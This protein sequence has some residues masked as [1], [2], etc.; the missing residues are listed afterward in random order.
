MIPSNRLC[1]EPRCYFLT[2]IGLETSA[3][4]GIFGAD[5][6]IRTRSISESLRNQLV[7]H[8]KSTSL[9]K[10]ARNID[11]ATQERLSIQ[12][13]LGQKVYELTELKKHSDGIRAELE[14]YKED[15]VAER[16]KS[17]QAQ[18]K[19]LDL[20]FQLEEKASELA[21]TKKENRKALETLE[22]EKESA[23]AAVDQKLAESEE[24]LERANRKAKDTMD[25]LI[26][27]QRGTTKAEESMEENEKTSRQLRTELEAALEQVSVVNRKLNRETTQSTG[28]RERLR[29]LKES[30]N[31]KLLQVNRKLSKEKTDAE[32]LRGDIGGIQEQLAQSRENLAA[33]E[34]TTKELRQSIIDAE[35]EI[36]ASQRQ[37]LEQ[38]LEIERLRAHAI[39]VEESNKAFEKA[40]AGLKNRIEELDEKLMEDDNTIK[41]MGNSWKTES[42]DQ[43][44]EIR[45]LKS[46]VTRQQLGLDNR[47]KEIR[48]MEGI[49]Q[50]QNNTFTRLR[51]LNRSKDEYIGTIALAYEYSLQEQEQKFRDQSEY[52]YHLSEKERE[53]GCQEL[54]K[55]LFDLQEE[56]MRQLVKV[57]DLQKILGFTAETARKDGLKI[58][59]LETQLH[60]VRQRHTEVSGINGLLSARLESLQGQ[61]RDMTV[62]CGIFQT[63]LGSSI[64]RLRKYRYRYNIQSRD[65]LRTKLDY[66]GCRG[67]L[68]RARRTSQRLETRRNDLEAQL[69][70]VERN[71]GACQDALAGNRAELQQVKDDLMTTKE[72]LEISTG[73]GTA[74][75][76]QVNQVKVVLR[77]ILPVHLRIVAPEQCW[78]RL[79]SVMVI[80]PNGIAKTLG[81]Q[82]VAHWGIYMRDLS[83]D[84][85]INPDMVKNNN[86]T[87]AASLYVRMDSGIFD[88]ETFQV[89]NL[90]S[91]RVAQNM[92]L[93]AVH[94][95]W[96][97]ITRFCASELPQ[98]DDRA[99]LF[100]VAVLHLEQR[101]KSMFEGFVGNANLECLGTLIGTSDVLISRLPEILTSEDVVGTAQGIFPDSS[102]VTADAAGGSR[103][104]TA[105]TLE[106]E[107]VLHINTTLHQV[108]LLVK[109]AFREELDW[110]DKVMFDGR[111]GLSAI[112]WNCAQPWDKTFWY[113]HLLNSPFFPFRDEVLHG[114]ITSGEDVNATW[115]MK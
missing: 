8:E 104:C 52:E 99:A 56:Y 39:E 21:K 61:E 81:K 44:N 75:H 43:K 88:M 65:F 33:E 53:M 71:L 103:T 92:D 55:E 22:S 58:T 40:E 64:S 31:T 46:K 51:A 42:D 18:S 10:L 74:L 96:Q 73:N 29:V 41:A 2:I 32:N 98:N 13:R 49:M 59:E 34:N 5:L 50:R 112:S 93:T 80:P 114:M 17:L 27:A 108:H 76:S 14:R 26:E 1:L 113:E 70:R 89:I 85:K 28:L 9:D 110:E 79:V 69:G 84:T 6:G 90:L 66:A 45:L 102:G 72:E 36:N 16:K 68:K 24:S 62:K 37:A 86:S 15:L 109:S 106:S 100:A 19:V 7:N 3:I 95:I 48:A 4:G 115:Y 23:V 57:Q 111:D 60:T 63:E 67:Q 91:G 83:P 107:Y 54:D 82:E 25:K 97:S 35:E 47:N 105:S 38:K 11:I 94:I 20:K 12:D 78:Y 87:L 30:Y 77:E 101:L